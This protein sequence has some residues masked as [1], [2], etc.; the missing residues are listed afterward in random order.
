VNEAIKKINR[1]RK[2]H[3]ANIMY[4][5]KKFSNDAVKLSRDLNKLSNIFKNG[6]ANIT[7]CMTWS[8]LP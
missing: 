2:I 8:E 3:E 7:A 5:F 6:T 1:S 4:K